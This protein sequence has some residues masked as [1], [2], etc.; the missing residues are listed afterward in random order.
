MAGKGGKVAGA[1]RKTKDEENRIR[2][3]MKP[4]CPA[5]IQCLFK[6]V[7]NKDSRDADKISAAKLIIAYTYGNPK[8]TVDQNVNINNFDLKEVLQ[9]DN[10]K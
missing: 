1:G 3:L 10:S 8:E 2:D 7:T 4:N 9:F 5:A 6:I